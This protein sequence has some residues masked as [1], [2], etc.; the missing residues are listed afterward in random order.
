[1]RKRF[2][3]NMPQYGENDTGVFV[4]K[5]NLLYEKLNEMK[6]EYLRKTDIANKKS[7]QHEEFD[8]L[9]IIP[10]LSIQQYKI[11]FLRWILDDKV[12]GF[13]TIEEAKFHEERIRQSD[14]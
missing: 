1:M 2:N 10:M 14:Y 5:G 9:E 11:L 8:F 6:K 12:L 13:N 3:D 7:E 4:I